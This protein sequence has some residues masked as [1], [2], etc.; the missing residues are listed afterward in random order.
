LVRS[1]AEAAWR[2]PN[3]NCPAQIK[4]RVEHFASA[5]C[6]GIHGLGSVTVDK[7]VQRGRVKNVADL[8]KL[9][10]EDLLSPSGLVGKSTINLLV[11][12]EQSKRVELWRFINGLGIPQV[13][14]V[15]A[16]ALALRFDGLAALAAS[17]QEDFF[18]D[19]QTS[20]RGVGEG[21]ARAVLTYFARSENQETVRDLI[22][23]GV[24][25]TTSEGL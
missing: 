4:R 7:L 10:E 23:L 9:R 16:R 12:I 2:C 15:A 18:Q 13:G 3:V 19:G 1:A 21:P 8:Y 11:A 25:P 24:R 5:G 22:A 20:I 14:Q 17:R 6:V